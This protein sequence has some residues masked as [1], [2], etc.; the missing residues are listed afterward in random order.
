VLERL[1]PVG[2]AEEI[3]P[4]ATTAELSQLRRLYTA[5]SL[6]MFTDRPD[7]GA[8]YVEH[9]LEA[10]PRYDPFPGGFSRYWEAAAHL[11]A[12]R[13]QRWWGLLSNLPTIGISRRA[14]LQH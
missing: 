11:H 6:C 2:W 1:E 4:A 10:E 8:G 5:A 7:A 13:S 12:G 3:L 14:N 9:A